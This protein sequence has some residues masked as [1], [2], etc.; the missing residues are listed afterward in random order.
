VSRA[1]ARA[2]FRAAL[3]DNADDLMAYLERRTRSRDDAADALGETFLQAW[4]RYD[5]FPDEPT[6]Q[7]MWLYGIASRVLANQGRSTRRRSALTERLRGLLMTS[8]AETHDVAEANAVR[9]AVLRL[10]ATQRELVIM[11]HWEGL[12]LLEASERLGI[13]PSTARSRYAT[14]RKLLRDAFTQIPPPAPGPVA[15]DK[16]PERRHASRTA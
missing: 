16:R 4:R 1:E 15:G 6:S 12:S 14:A 2:E 3:R 9:D 13:N 10:P 8:A 7:R 5:A 11:L